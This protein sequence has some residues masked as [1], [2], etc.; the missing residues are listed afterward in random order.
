MMLSS[1]DLHPGELRDR[2]HERAWRSSARITRSTTVI[3]EGRAMHS[4]ASPSL[5]PF[6]GATR[7]ARHL[8][9]VFGSLQSK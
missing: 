1:R 6:D 7:V 8:D 9:A 5:L 4:A 2:R 3:L